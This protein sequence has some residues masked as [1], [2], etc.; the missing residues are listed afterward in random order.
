MR[1]SRTFS[2]QNVNI[3]SYAFHHED[4]E[5]S[6]K[7]YFSVEASSFHK[8]F[9]GYEPAEVDERLDARLAELEFA[10]ALTVL[11]AVEAAFRI[12]YLPRCDLKKKDPIS[13]TF[14][15]IYKK[16][17]DRARLDDD[18]L[19]AWKTH[20]RGSTKLISVGPKTC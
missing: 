11:S 7:L 10:A 16:K 3:Q 17:K 6:L 1:K 12:D 20:T 13:T 15:E 5:R 19:D 18:I 9:L 2:K 14:R 4:M 8:R